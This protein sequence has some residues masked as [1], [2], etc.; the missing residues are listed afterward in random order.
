M[1]TASKRTCMTGRVTLYTR[2]GLDWTNR[3][4]TIATDPLRTSDRDGG[5]TNGFMQPAKHGIVTL[6]WVETNGAGQWLSLS[7]DENS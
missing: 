1:D 2:S 7:H 4:A 3:F 5:C 6:R